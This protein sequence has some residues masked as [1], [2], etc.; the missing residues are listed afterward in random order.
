MIEKKDCSI[1]G[2]SNLIEITN[3]GKSP[4][5]NNFTNNADKI[6][7]SYPLIVD[8]CGACS[9]IQL[10]HCLSEAELYS[11]YTY[12]TPNAIS[13]QNHYEDILK[14][15]KDLDFVN[16]EKKCI[17]IGS[18]NG[19]LLKFL[20]PHFKK[21]LGVDPAE[22]IAEI[23]NNYGIETWIDFFSEEV[24]EKII[25]KFERFNVGIARHMF[26]HNN[27]PKKLIAAMSAVLDDDGIFIIENAYAI[28]TFKNGEFDQ[29]YHE[30]MFYYSL[31]NMDFLL[32]EFNFEVSDLMFSPVH[33]GSMVFICSRKNKLPINDIVTSTLKIENQYFSENKI[34]DDFSIKINALKKDI[35]NLFSEASKNNLIV[36]SY[37]APAKAF[38]MFSFLDLD[39]KDIKFC[40]D[41]TPTKINKFFPNFGIPVISEESLK[42]E[43]YDILLINAW[44]YKEEIKAKSKNIFKKGTKLVFPIPYLEIFEV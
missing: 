25:K 43:I 9:C 11:H 21:V 30:H 42:D 40:V 28:D 24:A 19:N 3:L 23:A 5:A 6:V 26:A 14:K 35:K 7:E 41:T 10:R 36:G 8:Y 33:G 29:I 1:C 20:N 39:K 13:L 16:N 18:N 12:S 27:D 37:G 17:E 44:N 31:T 15:L 4:P 22:N 34:F 32:K 2:N 38:T